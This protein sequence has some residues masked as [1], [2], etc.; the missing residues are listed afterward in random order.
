[1]G[2]DAH[3]QFNFNKADNIPP[4]SA[5]PPQTTASDDLI[6][7]GSNPSSPRLD[8]TM[9]VDV[10]LGASASSDHAVALIGVEGMHCKSCVKKLSLIHI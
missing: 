3:P 10:D 4:A 5:S 2:F 7:L 8:Q 1:M 9:M 6:N